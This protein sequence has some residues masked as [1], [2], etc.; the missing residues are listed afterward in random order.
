MTK[1]SFLKSKTLLVLIPVLVL[2]LLILGY[3]SISNNSQKAQKT[4]SQSSISTSSQAN[5]ISQNLSQS[6]FTSSN[7]SNIWEKGQNQNRSNFISGNLT[8]ISQ[9]IP[10]ILK[11]CA[12]N[13]ENG[14]ASCVE[15]TQKIPNSKKYK[16]S[17]NSIN[18]KIEIPK[19]KY[20][21]YYVA[22]NSIYGNFSELSE[23]FWQNRDNQN[24]ENICSSIDLELRKNQKSIIIS[25]DKDTDNSQI[26]LGIVGGIE[27]AKTGLNL[28]NPINYF[29]LSLMKI[30]SDK[31]KPLVADAEHDVVVLEECDLAVK[32]VKNVDNNKVR[33][34]NGPS[35]SDPNFISETRFLSRNQ[36]KG[37]YISCFK[38]D[39]N[40]SK[41]SD[42]Q[43]TK[44]QSSQL[45]YKA[46]SAEDF[47]KENNWLA[48][49]VDIKNINSFIYKN[50]TQYSI[51]KGV[52]FV[53]NNKGYGINYMGGFESLVQIQFNS[54][55][56]STPSVKL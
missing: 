16:E 32:F 48:N 41:I 3:F 54:L 24:A 36:D 19:G 35:S 27:E 28:K 22:E 17:A 33:F 12:E 39:Q 30:S 55:A 29:H 25:V 8:Y 6:N 23:C 50:Q 46:L 31:I 42:E 15:N 7:S 11:I 53:Y 2:F 44:P 38:N 20:K 26:P 51:E 47:K 43:N 56:P 9:E 34:F 18:Y 14:V 10:D 37:F 45:D 49:P 5:S 21:F 40:I 13:Q 4:S 52:S 1:S